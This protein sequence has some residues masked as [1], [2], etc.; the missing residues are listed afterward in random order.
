MERRCV[1]VA[2]VCVALSR[3]DALLL[4]PKLCHVVPCPLR[5]PISDKAKAQQI[6]GGGA[7]RTY[8]LCCVRRAP[9]KN[10]EAF[11]RLIQVLPPHL[12]S[13]G[14]LVPFVCGAIV[15]PE[16]D[17]DIRRRLLEIAP[18]SIFVDRFL[19]PDELGHVFSRAVLNVHPALYE[20]Y[21]MTMVEAAAFGCP[22]LSHYDPSAGDAQ[23]IG[24][25]SLLRPDRSEILSMDLSRIGGD[26][27]DRV[28]SVLVDV[29]LWTT[30]S[31]CARRRSLEYTQDACGRLMMQ[32]CGLS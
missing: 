14:R 11:V 24:V 27:I 28:V 5:T 29:E 2:D 1:A 6:D 25:H 13:E 26:T 30:Y 4:H 19:T 9:E 31:T 21:G 17:A 23:P 7:S 18:Q 22:S 3:S 10:L 20:A 15:C 8:I 16:Y 12:L 32:N